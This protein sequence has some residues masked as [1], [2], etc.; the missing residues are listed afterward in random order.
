MA[1][2]GLKGLLIMAKPK[3]KAEDEGPPSEGGD[4]DRYL[5]MAFDAQGDGDREGYVEAMKMAIRACIAAEG[6]GEY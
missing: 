1:K 3:G 6:K 2:D 5:G 4:E